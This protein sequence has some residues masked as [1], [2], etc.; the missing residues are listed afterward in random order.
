MIREKKGIHL[1]LLLVPAVGLLLT[2]IVSFKTY[3]SEHSK[4]QTVFNEA[5]A[6]R[7][8]QIEDAIQS[9]VWTVESFSSFYASSS[10]VEQ[11][12]FNI[13]A[14]GYFR[15]QPQIFEFRWLRRV[16]ESKRQEYE[17]AGRALGLPDLKI[18]EID[19]AGNFTPAPQKQEYFVVDFISTSPNSKYD[20]KRI[21][22]LDISS[23]PERWQAMERARDTE[24]PAIAVETEHYEGLDIPSASR[25]FAPIYINGLPHN[26]LE[27]RRENLT[28]FVVL[29][30]RLDELVGISLKGIPAAG[31]DI[32][33]YDSA[34][35]G[36]RLLYFYP[37]PM[38]RNPVAA[39]AL[40]P[41][42]AKKS[43]F[44]W[45]NTL[46]V[47]DRKWT[48]IFSPC[49]EF[50]IKNRSI[51]PWV[52]FGTGLFLTLLL[53][54]YLRNII[55]RG[56]QV[57]LL[58]KRRTEELDR[59]NQE[60]LETFNAISDFVF[61]LDKDSVIIKVNKS[62]LDVLKTGERDIVGRKCFEV[63]HK[64]DSPWLSCPH[65]QTLKDNKAHTE[66]VSD[67]GLGLPLLV[68]TSPVF[69]E[70]GELVGS[71]H[72]AKDISAIKKTENDLIK[73]K[74][75]L[76]IEAWGLAKANEGIKALYGELEQK[77][78]ELKKIDQL[79]SDFVSIV[80]HELRTPLAIMKE[81]VSLVLDKVTGE[82]TP[83]T[84]TTLEMVYNNINRLAKLINDLLDI[85]KIEAGKLQLKRTLTDMNRLVRDTAE[86]WLISAKKKDQE[87]SIITGDERLNLYIDQDKLIQVL[88]NLLSNAIK[89]TP[90]KGRI[91][92]QVRGDKDEA[93]VSVSDNGAGIPGED[94]PRVF[95][96]FQQF[97]R[98]AGGGAK[99]TGLGLAICK[100]LV[101]LHE[102]SIKV[103][104][105]F[106]SG[107]K[108]SFTLPKK[109]SE[110]VFKEHIV[111]GI[112]EVADRNSNLAL[113]SMRILDFGRLQKA[114]GP[115]MTHSLL[116][117]IEKVINESLRRKADTVVR[118][119]GELIVILFDTTKDQA[120]FVLG[121]IDAVIR[122]F[123]INSRDEAVK[124]TAF[125]Y[126][127]SSYPNE[128]KNELELLDKARG[129]IHV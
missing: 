35:A 63:M 76:E 67:P 31:V 55:E 43:S 61:I 81:G 33:F 103:E 2:A 38:R 106:G 23:I 127:I 5:S 50:L 117:E 57:E 112:K 102:G 17:T 3:Q 77:N 119:T 64:K 80:S 14:Q 13:F 45:S 16:P 72:I 123:L 126:G 79:K 129:V 21:F 91:T 97:D 74:G 49:P 28:G 30:F 70:R 6:Y 9:S 88:N 98:T 12:E 48:M 108:F 32:A 19:K 44:Y 100:E 92:V 99:G 118:D 1:S 110:T 56:K 111:E 40:S 26:T 65:Q 4:V 52:T 53:M 94:L 15:R 124:I 36:E 121:R 84:G 104:S 115:D 41:K 27:E 114:L 54:F 116:Q 8:K 78:Q 85:S 107:T 59:A 51:L 62:L 47:A 73:T 95:G 83:K 46:Q 58:V 34:P 120:Q 125:N 109:D 10:S 66:E 25:I 11:S 20:Y 37:S 7:F 89:F 86:K 71:V 75:E 42:E 113:I 128:A 93:E 82:I 69:D 18:K 90:E 22:G 105:I 87:I 24:E 101:E 68:S 39:E 96:K 29:L 122:N 60:W